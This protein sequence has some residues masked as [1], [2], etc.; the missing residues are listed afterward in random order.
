MLVLWPMPMYGSGYIFSKPFFTG[1]VVV[2]ILWIFCSFFAVGLFPIFEGRATLIHTVKSMAS[3]KK[4]T[5]HISTQGE[6][7]ANEKTSPGTATPEKK[8]E[9]ANETITSS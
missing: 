5:R 9:G 1:W 3:G 4:P 2:G 7:E 8:S 6:E